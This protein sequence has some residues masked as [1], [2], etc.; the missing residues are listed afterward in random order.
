MHNTLSGFGRDM[1]RSGARGNVSGLVETPMIFEEPT[2]AE[3]AAD[4]NTTINHK[5]G[6]ARSGVQMD[7]AADDEQPVS[8]GVTPVG[9][10]LPPFLVKTY[11]MVDDEATTDLVSWSDEGKRYDA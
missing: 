7:T 5:N 2:D 9:L 8:S 4:A 3:E 11:D 6:A 10:Q 1:E